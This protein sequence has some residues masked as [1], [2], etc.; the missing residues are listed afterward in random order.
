[1]GASYQLSFDPYQTQYTQDAGGAMLDRAALAATPGVT[2]RRG[3]RGG[4]C[5]Q[6]ARVSHG[7]WVGRACLCRAAVNAPLLPPAPQSTDGSPT[8]SFGWGNPGAFETQEEARAAFLAALKQV[9]SVG[10]AGVGPALPGTPSQPH[11]CGV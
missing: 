1:M 10:G 8:L 5:A 2:V 7:A 6:C 4:R 9:C 11:A 3:S